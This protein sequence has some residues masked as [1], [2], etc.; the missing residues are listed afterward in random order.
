MSSETYHVREASSSAPSPRVKSPP[1]AS[2][3]S[4]PF[5]YTPSDDGT[6]ENLLIL[7]HG[8]GD[9][10]IPF[11][12]LGRSLNLPQTA[13]LALRAP[14]KIPYL[15]QEAYQ[16]YPSFDRLGEMIPH[17]N[18]TPALDYLAT[19]LDHLTRDCAWPP[20]RIH[21]FGFAQ[22]GSVAAESALRWWRR[23][24]ET[25]DAT[26]PRALGSVVTVAGPLLSYPTLSTPCPTPLLA[27][28]HPDSADSALPG[29]ALTAF[30]KGFRAIAEAKKRGE[31]MPRSKE[32]WFPIMKFWSEYLGRRQVEG[33]YEVLSGSVPT[34][35]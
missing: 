24:L 6:D 19:A 33:L 17:P 29:D 11:G 22:G 15:F 9:T 2:V 1:K 14:E 34:Q 25:K 4:A 8:L 35:Q 16:W 31:G 7:L 32:E 18:P 13:T 3:L 20:H 12:K 21:L 5:T 10:H 26:P 30:R 27:F 23:E 28:H